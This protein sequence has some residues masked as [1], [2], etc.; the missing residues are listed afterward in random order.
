MRIR[1]NIVRSVHKDKLEKRIMERM[2]KKLYEI[3]LTSKVTK[4][5]KSLNLCSK[6]EI[7]RDI[8]RTE[9][10]VPRTINMNK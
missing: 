4:I 9:F 2:R 6:E 8:K 7:F 5:G 3:C 10:L 1:M